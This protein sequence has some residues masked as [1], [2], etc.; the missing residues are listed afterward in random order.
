M[1][2]LL[3]ASLLSAASAAS[4]PIVFAVLPSQT[5]G[6]WEGW[7]VSLAWSGVVWG[8]SV[9]LADALFS[10]Q[11]AVQMPDG[12]G[13][14]PGLGLNIVRYNVRFAPAPAPASLFLLYPR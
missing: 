6:T 12:L 13:A 8:S 9:P 2:R 4:P 10:L 5:Y 11:D 14:V 3:S 7:G 1:L